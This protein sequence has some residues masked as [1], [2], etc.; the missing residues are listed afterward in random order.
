MS[1]IKVWKTI[2][3]GGSSLGEIFQQLRNDRR[4]IEDL[5]GINIPVVPNRQKIKLVVVSGRSLGYKSDVL[6]SDFYKTAFQSGLSLCPAEVGL[7]LMLHNRE[8]FVDTV[9]IAMEPIM[10]HGSIY[11][12]KIVVPSQFQIFRDDERN[13]EEVDWRFMVVWSEYE[14]EEKIHC[15]QEFMFQLSKSK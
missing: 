9:T 5:I 3:I 11:S 7:Q 4:N 6:T 8:L 1:K 10:A 15:S 14:P 2:Q 12:R 13:K